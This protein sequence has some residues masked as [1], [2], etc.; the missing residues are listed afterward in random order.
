MAIVWKPETK[1]KE[2]INTFKAV[3]EKKVLE[4]QE[5]AGAERKKALSNFLSGEGWLR[6][7]DVDCFS[8]EEAGIMSGRLMPKIRSLVTWTTKRQRLCKIKSPTLSNAGSS[9]RLPTEVLREKKSSSYFNKNWARK[10]RVYCG[11][12]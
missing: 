12:A 4:A 3:T 6:G 11:R 9:A 5:L 8:E 7:S 10:T 2:R 1:R